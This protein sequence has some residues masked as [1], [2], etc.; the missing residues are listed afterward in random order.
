MKIK[1]ITC[2]DVYNVGASLQ[3]YALVT[4]LRSLGHDAEIIDYKP[5]YLSNHYSLWGLSNSAYDR[6]VLRE[7]YN[8]AK[9]PG[10]L[11]ARHSKRKKCFDA[12]TRD[13]L[14]KT[15]QRYSSNED[16]KKNP[17]EADIYLAGSDQIWNCFFQ[18]GKDPAFYLDFAPAG[19]I[20]ASYA[21]SF[22]TEDV[23]EERKPQIRQWLSALDYI[24]VRESSGVEIVNRLGI[25]GAV[26][27]LD[28]VFL[29]SKEEWGQL[30]K[31][32]P[33]KE[34]F[35]FLYD[36][37]G[38]EALS[39]AV[40]K[41]ADKQGWKVYSY[42]SNPHADRCFDQYGPLTFL[43]LVEEAELVMSNSFHATA[44]SLIFG[45]NFWVVNRREA[46]NTRM[47]DLTL[48]AGVPERLRTE[49]EGD[50]LLPVDYEKVGATL[51]NGIRKSQIFINN[52]LE[53]VEKNEKT[54]E[55]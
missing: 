7:L 55:F 48:L 30:V 37:D 11:K 20:K 40:R 24:S 38:N 36:F 23:A 51:E 52:V 39:K 44:F 26:Q 46:I 34:P 19:S 35:I 15:E 31:P 27:V 21:A 47:R 14:P 43:S 32:L 49:F 4:Y 33:Q 25:P 12:F 29:L 41:L 8:L 10:R 6:P 9:L 42:L 17:P 1:T 13:Y 28:P 54:N 3:A 53:R 18:N 5:D 2:H 50:L 16:L 45:K 22:S